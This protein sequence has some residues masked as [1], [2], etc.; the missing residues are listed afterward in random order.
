[1]RNETVTRY[2]GES[3]KNRTQLALGAVLATA[4]GLG[5]ALSLILDW[6]NLARPWLVL[7]GFGFGLAA[8]VGTAL[9][10]FGL[11]ARRREQSE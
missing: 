1:M 6:T 5:I 9:A 2:T 11:L 10:I 7:V 8:R 4:G 3:M